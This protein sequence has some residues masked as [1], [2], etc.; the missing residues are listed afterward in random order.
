VDKVGY[1][2]TMA[3]MM[4]DFLRATGLLL[5]LLNPFLLVIYLIDVVQTVEGPRFRKVLCR[6]GVLAWAV[7]LA[8]AA[9]GETIFNDFLQTSFA[10]FQIFGGLIFLLIGI[11]FVFYGPKAITLL[12]GDAE[13]LVGNIAIPVF[14]GPG[15]I[16]ACVVLEKRHDFALAAAATTT[17]IAICVL[18]MIGLKALHDWVR[19]RYEP[20]VQRYIE[21]AGRL[22]AFVVGT[23]AVE[24][25]CNGVGS[26]FQVLS[27]Q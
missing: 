14:I 23:I 2:S 13:D 10:S 25:I 20:L 8:F 5:V 16:S 27:L 12:R 3:A 6:A 11:Q 4:G 17:A 19:P 22:F 7:F 1:A 21:I 24:M 18:V 26:W 15:T 9:L